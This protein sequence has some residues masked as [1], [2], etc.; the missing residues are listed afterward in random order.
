MP[1][2]DWKRVGAGVFHDFHNTWIVHLKNALNAGLLPP[3]FYAISEQHAGETQ[4][5]VLTLKTDGQEETSAPKPHGGMTAVAEA[6]PKVSVTMTPDEAAAY[7]LKRR[8]LV[9][10]YQHDHRIVALVEILSHGNKDRRSALDTF[11]DKVIS[12]LKYGYHFLVVDLHPPGRF[13]PNG[14]HG[15]LWD[16]ITGAAYDAPEDKPL[17]LAAYEANWLPSAY[18]EPVSVGSILPDMPLFLETGWYI[19]VPLE[20]TY[21]A[22]YEGVPSVWRDVIEGNTDDRGET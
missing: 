13:D 15:V 2:H 20:Q 4:P 18:V 21:M 14:I 3:D 12:A 7:V 10:R 19:N 9:I 8:T 16:E 11:V 6:P 22:A 1:V 17:T 5:D